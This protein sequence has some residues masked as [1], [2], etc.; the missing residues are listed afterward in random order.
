M[1]APQTLQNNDKTIQGAGFELGDNF[2]KV[3]GPGAEVGGGADLLLQLS[4]PIPLHFIHHLFRP[5]E[6]SQLK[7]AY[8]A[9]KNV[10]KSIVHYGFRIS[11]QITTWRSELKSNQHY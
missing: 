6:L 8:Q 10:H 1:E 5:L 4:F 7:A 3:P 9:L 2:P 11:L